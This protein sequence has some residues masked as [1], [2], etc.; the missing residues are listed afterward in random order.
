MSN[1]EFYKLDSIYID[2]ILQKGYKA[3]LPV[4]ECALYQSFGSKLLSS[5]EINVPGLF[6]FFS[7][8]SNHLFLRLTFFAR[9]CRLPMYFSKK[10]KK[11]EKVTICHFIRANL[12]CII[13]DGGIV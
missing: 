1:V 8:D 11:T 10:S 9:C 3:H 13:L 7:Y 6:F 5:L 2:L 12:P 4:P